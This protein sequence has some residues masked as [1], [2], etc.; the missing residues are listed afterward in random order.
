MHPAPGTVG[1][2][3]DMGSSATTVSTRRSDDR[4]ETRHYD[5]RDG[6]DVDLAEAI[7]AAGK[8]PASVALTVPAAWKSTRRLAHAEAAANAGFDVGVLVSEPEAAARYLAEAEGVEPNPGEALV[9]C[10]LGAASCN[11]GVV[12]REGDRYHVEAAK[13]VD[14]L[15]GRA[16]DRLLL[17]YLASRHRGGEPE[18]WRRVADPAETALRTAMLAEIRRAREHL[19]EHPAAALRL[20]GSDRELRLSR[21]EAEQCLTPAVLQ[22]TALVEDAMMEAGIGADERA[23]L[24]LVGGASRTPLVAAVIRHHLGIEPVLPELPELV[25]AEGAALAAL[26]RAEAPAPE[27]A[28]PPPE[29]LRTSP[30]VLVTALVVGVAIAAIVGAALMNRDPGDSIGAEAVTDGVGFGS[31]PIATDESDP[32]VTDEPESGATP[33][34]DAQDGE[35]VST[36]ASDAPD[37]LE[38]TPSAPA[39]ATETPAAEVT[40]GAAAEETSA[41]V[42]NVIGNTLAEA[43]R[44]LAEA[45]FHNVTVQ[46]ERRTGSEYDHCETTAQSPGGGSQAEHGV[47]IIVSYVYVGS[48]D[49]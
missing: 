15:G 25:L 47:P 23:G 38:P 14:D 32:A 40:S 5:H 43:R 18:F 29:R 34:P 24:V 27:E 45:G 9:V 12:R 48:D 35:G 20:P 22:T 2:G 31:L 33:A 4:P 10:G 28:A 8:G 49:C 11:V 16:F 36:D 39:T 30:G 6:P 19:T 13:S 7:R 41:E 26:A 1:V 46:G 37:A 3:V 42:P 44:I 21:E 17:D